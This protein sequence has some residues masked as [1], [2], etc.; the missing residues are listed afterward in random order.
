MSKIILNF[1]IIITSI[2]FILLILFILDLII[3]PNSKIPLFGAIG[4]ILSA[5]IA[6]ASVHK[7]IKSNEEIKENETKKHKEKHLFYFKCNIEFFEKEIEKYKNIFSPSPSRMSDIQIASINQTPI[8]LKEHLYKLN[9]IDFIFVLPQ[10]C[11]N[12]FL[13]LISEITVLEEFVQNINPKR[14]SA[15]YIAK[16]G[17]VIKNIEKILEINKEILEKLA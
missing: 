8:K 16:K 1:L 13:S 6:S 15:H 7:S 14:N 3:I 10:N 12:L 17:E 5:F 2:F 11:I 9:S 4:I